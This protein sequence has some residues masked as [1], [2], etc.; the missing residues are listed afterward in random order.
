MFIS[1]HPS[2]Q[3]T[4]AV[5]LRPFTGPQ[6]TGRDN[7]D[8]KDYVYTALGDM[9]RPSGGLGYTYAATASP[10][11]LS[12]SNHPANPNANLAPVPNAPVPGGNALS[13]QAV[14]PP[15]G[16]PG[17]VTP[18]I[19]FKNVRCLTDSYFID[20]FSPK[21]VS[22]VPEPVRNPGYIGRVTIVGMGRG[23]KEHGLLNPGRCVKR[24]VTRVL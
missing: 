22:M 4:T 19:V 7:G 10:D 1:S 8:S 23:N 20:V 9:A 13:I 5:P 3:Y 11:A 6:A 21:A 16:N 24:G 12:A 17:T 14:R 18:F 2:E 15:A